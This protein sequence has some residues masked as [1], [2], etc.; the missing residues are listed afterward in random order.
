[1]LARVAPIGR[2]TSVARRAA[3]GAV[4]AA[5]LAGCTLV[6]PNGE[7]TDPSEGLGSVTTPSPTAAEA[8]T[9]SPPA[10]QAA[11][12]DEAVTVLD[13]AGPVERSVAISP[14]LST[15]APLVR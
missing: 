8:P 2:G 7:R 5:V 4:V 1:P 12:P 10:A 14:T 9:P 6:P 15:S 13:D 3:L 11:L